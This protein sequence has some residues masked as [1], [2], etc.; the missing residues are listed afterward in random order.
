MA[1]TVKQQ[2]AH[3]GVHKVAEPCAEHPRDKYNTKF[4]NICDYLK[5]H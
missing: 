1:T 2:D 3:R 4:G 5:Y